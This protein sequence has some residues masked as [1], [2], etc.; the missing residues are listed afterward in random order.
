MNYEKKY[1]SD[2]IKKMLSGIKMAKQVLKENP[3][4]HWVKKGL[5]VMDQ[6]LAQLMAAS[7]NKSDK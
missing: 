6:Y 3:D 4:D 1:V 7:E 2:D 5:V